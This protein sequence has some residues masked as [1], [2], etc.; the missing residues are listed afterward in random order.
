MGKNIPEKPTASIFKEVT[1][2]LKM[3]ADYAVSQPKT[4]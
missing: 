3:E 4:P 1:F 2:T